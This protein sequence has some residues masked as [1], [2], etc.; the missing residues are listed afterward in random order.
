MYII[1]M[2]PVYILCINVY[3][4]TLPSLFWSS[5]LFKTPITLSIAV[6]STESVIYKEKENGPGEQGQTLCG[7]PRMALNFCSWKF[8]STVFYTFCV[9]VSGRNSTYDLHV[10]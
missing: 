4:L 7:W 3:K 8:F 2:Q 5:Y 9:M 1:Y 10:L 6:L